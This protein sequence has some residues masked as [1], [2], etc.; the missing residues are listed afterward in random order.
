MPVEVGLD[1][2]SVEFHELIYLYGKSLKDFV[3]LQK[4]TQSAWNG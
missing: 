1:R 4:L 2:V 3:M